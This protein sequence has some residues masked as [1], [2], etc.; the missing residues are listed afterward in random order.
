MKMN[1]LIVACLLTALSSAAQ[2]REL[3][4]TTAGSLPDMIPLSEKH[5]ITELKL[6]GQLNG[7]DFREQMYNRNLRMANLRASI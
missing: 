2:H 5:T 3:T 4:V 1:I 7:T 6:K